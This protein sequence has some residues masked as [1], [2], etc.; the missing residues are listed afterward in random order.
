MKKAMGVEVKVTKK[1]IDQVLNGEAS[2]SGKMKQLFD[3]GLEVKEIAGLMDVRYNFAYNVVSN[4]VAMN[5]IVTE[6]TKKAGKKEQII[7]LWEA[8]KSNKEISIE[9][10]TNYNYVFNV[11]KAHKA[12]LPKVDLEKKD[13]K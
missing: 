10:K 4:Y 12:T 3:L 11:V 1:A 7:Q 13:A 5:G 8:G 6:S 2:K 9:L